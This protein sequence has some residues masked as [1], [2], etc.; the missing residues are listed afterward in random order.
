MVASKIGCERL[1]F[2]GENF[3]PYWAINYEPV[4]V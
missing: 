3:A 4:K 2:I 1:K